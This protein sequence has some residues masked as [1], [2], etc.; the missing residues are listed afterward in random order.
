MFH[1]RAKLLHRLRRRTERRGQAM[2]EFGLVLPI[3]ILLIIG[4]IEFALAFNANLA[5]N[6][7]SREAALIGAE[8]GNDAIA[9]CRILQTIENSIDNPANA[10]RINQVRIYRAG[11]NGNELGANVY[12]RGGNITCTYWDGVEDQEITVHYTLI[13]EGYAVSGR[14]NQLEGCGAATLDTIGV[15]IDYTHPWITP[16]AG[17]V[18]LN[19]SGFTFD[20]SNAMRMEPV[21]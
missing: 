1:L 16:L 7:A 2:V 17:I 12:S 13:T 15:S 4:L 9:D 8:S 11:I 21:L 3:F 10:S 14:C 19:G 5:V 6:F 20:A 18:T